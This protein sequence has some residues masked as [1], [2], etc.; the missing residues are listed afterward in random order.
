[1]IYCPTDTAWREEQARRYAA[2]LQRVDRGR[3]VSLAWRIA[4]YAGMNVGRV[5]MRTMFLSGGL[6]GL[7]GFLQVSGASG[8]LTDNTAGG[9]G[10]TAITVAWLA[11]MNPFGMLVVSVF[12]AMLERGSNAIQTQFKIPASASDLLIGIILFFMLS[13][14]ST[15]LRPSRSNFFM[16]FIYRPPLQVFF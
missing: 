14:G 2:L 8:S 6:A 12:I 5:I 13:S 11:K 9:I 15:S 1:M 3:R 16:S 7:V 4:R 10:F